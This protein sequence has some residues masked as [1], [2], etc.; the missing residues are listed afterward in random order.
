MAKFAV[1]S[2]HIILPEQSQPRAGLILVDNEVIEDVVIFDVHV[3]LEFI[4][5]LYPE[6]ILLNYLEL[7]ISPGIIDL[8][9]R[10]EWESYSTLTKSAISGGVTFILEEPSFFNDTDQN[11]DFYC[12]IG[13]LQIVDDNNFQELDQGV[14]A[15]KVYLFP[16]AYSVKSLQNLSVIP[17]ILENSQIPLFIDPNLPDQRM[18]YM[19]SPFRLEAYQ[20][21]SETRG[22]S[23]CNIFA[24]AYGQEA[25]NSEDSTDEAK[26]P[27]RIQS[28]IEIANEHIVDENEIQEFK[29]TKGGDEIISN[30]NVPTV[31][32]TIPKGFTRVKRPRL[33]STSIVD[34]LN[35]KIKEEQKSYRTICEAESLSYSFSGLTNFSSIDSIEIRDPQEGS[36]SPESTNS[37]IQRSVRKRPSIIQTTTSAV[38]RK[39]QY[40][41]FLANCPE[42]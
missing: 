38:D 16:P 37:N 12:D 17:C 23:K 26:I 34:T 39:D 20:N 18:L 29:R 24:G 13:S 9:V 33:H 27:M 7:Y 8:S 10:K 22:I 30:P 42:H 4:R 3:T 35:N 19:S 36:Y 5:N 1:I 15:Y 40:S 14:C 28:L 41:Y 2:N 25:V 6:Y 21:R 11:E 31:D 32:E